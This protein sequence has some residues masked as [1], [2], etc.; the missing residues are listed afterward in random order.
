MHQLALIEKQLKKVREEA[1]GW[2]FD[3]YEFPYLVVR[4]RD[5]GKKEYRIRLDLQEYDLQPPKV[6]VL[7]FLGMLR[8]KRAGWP[9][10]SKFTHETTLPGT[11]DSWVCTVGVRAYHDHF[12]HVHNSWDRYRNWMDLHAVLKNLA[13]NMETPRPPNWRR[14]S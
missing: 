10:L 2:A 11:E 7:G 1:E 14:V 9:Q 5:L 12:V 4:M 6:D 3:S 8:A 13:R